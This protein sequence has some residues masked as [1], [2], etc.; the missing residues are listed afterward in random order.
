MVRKAAEGRTTRRSSSSSEAKTSSNKGRRKVSPAVTATVTA[1]DYW[2][3]F[4]GT[5]AFIPIITILATLVIVG[6]D[7]LI[8]WNGFNL[9]FKLL[10]VQI[11]IVFAVWII[12]ILVSLGN[13]KSDR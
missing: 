6:I 2:P 1:G 12:R 3:A 13:D 8:S 10:G 7:L 9:F 4:T 5:R 11:L